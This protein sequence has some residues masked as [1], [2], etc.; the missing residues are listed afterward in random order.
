MLC[1]K[2]DWM[3]KA[4]NYEDCFTDDLSPSEEKVCLSFRFT[5][6][7]QCHLISIR[8]DKEGDANPTLLVAD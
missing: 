4:D 2:Q 3:C 7:T 5:S 8:E 1:S 6:V